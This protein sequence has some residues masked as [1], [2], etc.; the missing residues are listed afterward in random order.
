MNRNSVC[1]LLA[2]AVG[3][4]LSGCGTYT[5]TE[6]IAFLQQPRSPVSGLAYH[7]MPPDVLE[8]S[9]QNVIEINAK[10]VKIR[11]D[12]KINLPLLGELYVAEMTP[13]QIEEQI[14]ATAIQYYKHEQVDATVTVLEYNSQ[15]YYVMGHVALPG[16]KIWTG[17]D[18]L[19]DAL[20]VAAPTNLAWE[21]RIKVIRSTA[22]ARGGFRVV[23]A[24]DE[25]GSI[26]HVPDVARDVPTVC[27]EEFDGL[28]HAEVAVHQRGA[29]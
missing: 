13:A 21:E 18:T 6:V 23:P 28:A 9:S 2:L 24:D 26:A 7:V 19:L 14:K 15:K 5:E 3:V 16:P 10:I 8:I 20:A 27:V 25:E 12:G 22:P 29:A 1:I 11:P 17:N 4:V